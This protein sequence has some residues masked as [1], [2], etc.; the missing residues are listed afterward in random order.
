MKFWNNPAVVGKTPLLTTALLG[1]SN[2][3]QL[4][5]MWTEHSA[6]GQ[7]V[8]GWVSVGGALWLFVNFYRVCCP[9]ERFVFWA[10][11]LE[12]LV[13]AAVVVSVIYFRHV[14]GR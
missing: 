5:Q 6:K 10:T 3:Q 14:G 9:K 1:W 2:V 7:S 4:W 12:C 11:V 8:W 13:N